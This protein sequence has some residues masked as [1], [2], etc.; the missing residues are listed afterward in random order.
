MKWGTPFARSVASGTIVMT[1]LVVGEWVTDILV[2]WGDVFR[3][4]RGLRS[5]T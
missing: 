1:Q 2:V 4:E 5:R 3:R